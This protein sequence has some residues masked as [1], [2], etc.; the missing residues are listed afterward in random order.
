MTAAVQKLLTEIESLS[1]SEKQEIAVE[2]LRRT[3]E[4][5]EVVANPNFDAE[6]ETLLFEGPN[7]PADFS[8]A[9]IYV[10]HD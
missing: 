4:R 1:D 8:R 3:V 2:I 6:L 9:D 5:D 10:E 7:L